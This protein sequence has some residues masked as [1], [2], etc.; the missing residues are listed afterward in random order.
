MDAIRAYIKSEV[1]NSGKRISGILDDARKQKKELIELI[2]TF[3]KIS[4][5]I[6]DK[7]TEE[8]IDEV[9]DIYI[10]INTLLSEISEKLE[11]VNKSGIDIYVRAVLPIKDEITKLLNTFNTKKL[12]NFRI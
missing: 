6:K 8:I 7:P 5:N 9:I 3:I 11:I 1:G 10:N 4:E 2:R 12:I